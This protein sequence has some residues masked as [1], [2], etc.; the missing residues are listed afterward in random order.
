MTTS[1]ENNVIIL[2]DN[3]APIDQ[4][5][6]KATI[7]DL[8]NKGYRNFYTPLS[9]E[10]ERVAA[11]IIFS[12]N[13]FGI[14]NKYPDL[15]LIIVIEHFQDHLR[16]VTSE[17]SDRFA[18][19]LDSAHEV[20]LIRSQ[21]TPSFCLSAASACF[22]EASLFLTNVDPDEMT[23]TCKGDEDLLVED[24]PLFV[25]YNQAEASQLPIINMCELM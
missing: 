16:S 1:K 14:N 24:F 5:K 23:I 18:K 15:H 4:T 6:L 25:L 11:E 21:R 20:I 10:F 3:F 7:V 22:D 19:I 2:G 17:Q 9:S 8:Y 13:V 12:L